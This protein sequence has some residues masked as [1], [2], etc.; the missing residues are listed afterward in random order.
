[1]QKHLRPK[2]EGKR[3][4]KWSLKVRLAEE[5]FYGLVVS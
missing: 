4:R 5:C 3:L 1:M 2:E